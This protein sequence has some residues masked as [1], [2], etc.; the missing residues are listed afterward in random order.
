MSN[1]GVG[2]ILE[3][4]YYFRSTS[5]GYKLSFSV[6]GEVDGRGEGGRLL[7]LSYIPGYFYLIFTL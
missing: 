6:K 5:L 4:I 2:D 1:N 7:R 3:L